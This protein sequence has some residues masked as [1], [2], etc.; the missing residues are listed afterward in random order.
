MHLPVLARQLNLQIVTL[1]IAKVVGLDILC[2]GTVLTENVQEPSLVQLAAAQR[3]S[4]P[5]ATAIAKI[6]LLLITAQGPGLA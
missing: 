6:A 2:G 1:D 3:A 5:T 4:T